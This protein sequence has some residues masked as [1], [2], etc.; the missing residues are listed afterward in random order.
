MICYVYKPKR[1]LPNGKVE[2]QRT[3]RGR[4]RLAGEFSVTDLAQSNISQRVAQELIRHSDPA[5]TANSYT[6][7]SQLPTFDAVA[8]LA[9]EGQNLTGNTRPDSQLDTQELVVNSHEVARNG[10]GNETVKTTETP[11]NTGQSHALPCA[12]TKSQMVGAVR[13]ELT[14]SCTRNTRASRATLRP[15]PSACET[16][17]GER[18]KQ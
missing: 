6:D 3:N 7:A 10:N 8:S 1:R 11:I 18:Q 16:A 4:Y 15:E 12:V 2:V 14:T 17:R 9:W 5:L 13:F